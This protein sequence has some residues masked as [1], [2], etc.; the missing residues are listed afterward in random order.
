MR[1]STL[2]PFGV[3]DFASFFRFH[4]R[5]P[6]L[7]PFWVI[8]H[9]FASFSR[10]YRRLY[11]FEFP[12][13]RHP[14]ASFGFFSTVLFPILMRTSHPLEDNQN[15]DEHQPQHAT[16]SEMKAT[17]DSTDLQTPAASTISNFKSRTSNS[18]KWK[19]TNIPTV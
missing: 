1:L 12:F 5:L 8:F 4:R 18:N 15:T 14:G 17:S 3:H 7:N 6:T 16:Q 11:T 9:D 13:A 19:Y 2:N 10:L